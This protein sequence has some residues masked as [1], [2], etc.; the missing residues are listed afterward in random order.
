[1]LNFRRSLIGT[2]PEVVSPGRSADGP[3]SAARA[4]GEGR[5]WWR[6]LFAGGTLRT[7]SVRAPRL[8]AGLAGLLGLILLCGCAASKPCVDAFP[9]P[10]VFGHDT[11][12][13]S[14]ELYWVYKVDPESGKTT[15]DVRQPEP[16]YALHCFPV[17]RAARKFFQHARFD[18]NLPPPDAAT[19]RALVRQVLKRSMN[20][21]V[22]EA[23][24]VTIPGYANLYDFSAAHESLLKSECGTMWRS[25]FQRGNWRMIFP[26]SRG[27]QEKMARQ[28]V[29][30]I[31]R[32]RPPVVHVVDFPGL[33][34]NHAVM[35]FDAREGE[36]EIE[37]SVYDPNDAS[38]PAR[39]KFERAKRRFYFPASF[40]YAG[41]RVDVYEIYRG[42]C[43]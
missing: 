13:Y 33:H 29:E 19:C 25:Y 22:G 6:C 32:R 18:A 11:L 31:R 17:A 2:H 4:K 20:E 24:R 14:N 9:R 36:T 42:S 41:G 5:W 23:D 39:L 26:F 35:L 1:M 16:T 37:F 34:I 7:R 12:A 8:D 27:Q 15:H 30:S 38:K 3:P 43:Y 28:L 40:Y 10:F 21:E